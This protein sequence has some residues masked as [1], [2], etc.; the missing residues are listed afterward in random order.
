MATP[1][2]NLM[3]DASASSEVT[4]LS[5]SNN[6][7]DNPNAGTMSYMALKAELEKST[8]EVVHAEFAPN[9]T[10]IRKE[11]G[12]AVTQE[13]IRVGPCMLLLS[14]SCKD[15]GLNIKQ[16]FKDPKFVICCDNTLKPRG[17][18]Y[19]KQRPFSDVETTE[20]LD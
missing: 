3:N 15:K 4:S 8:R 7:Q 1:L 16:I 9:Y 12:E 19:I 18:C 17:L 14:Q 5:I 13:A 10:Y 6:T 11:T 20:V 2:E